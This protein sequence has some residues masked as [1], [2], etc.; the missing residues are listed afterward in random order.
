MFFCDTPCTIFVSMYL[1]SPPIRVFT[2][3][4]VYQISDNKTGK[5][6][7]Y[8][9][10]HIKVLRECMSTTKWLVCVCVFV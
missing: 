2:S 4:I 1:H 3:R 7:W 8:A 6:N 5:A 9:E 10:V